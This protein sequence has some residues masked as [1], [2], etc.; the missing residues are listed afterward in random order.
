MAQAP[1]SHY[2]RTPNAPSFTS[3]DH[4]RISA[5][6]FGANFLWGAM[7]GP[8]LAHQMTVLAPAHS[9]AM[10]GKLMSV[11]AWPA[12]LI[13]LFTG[14]FSD[15]CRSKF[16]RRRPFIFWG[17]LISVL[18]LVAMGLAFS[19]R[20]LIPYI[21]AYFVIQVGSNVALAAYS[22]V[23]PD[24]VP[25]D[26]LGKASGLMAVMSQLGTL[27]GAIVCGMILG[28]SVTCLYVIAAVL[29]AFVGFT[30][31]SLR[32][33][34]DDQD[35]E[36]LRIGQVF[37]S[38]WID[39]RQYPDFAWVWL[40]RALMMLGFYMIQP[41]MQFYMHDLLHVD[42]PAKQSAIVFAVI[43]LAACLSGFFGGWMS[44][45]FGR[46]RIVVYSTLI[47]AVMSVVFIFLNNLNQALLAG[48]LFGI[49]YGAYISVDWALGTDVLPK[50]EDAASDMAVWHI[51]MTAPQI[52]GPVIAGTLVLDH[53]IVGHYVSPEGLSVAI[54][55]MSG[56]AVVF[57]M[58]AL[59][60]F[61]SGILVRKV[62]GST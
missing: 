16:G 23:I 3:L 15:R 21:A 36:A 58:C 45:H 51:A 55:G 33:K 28:G 49:G 31:L 6:W 1:A 43:L 13:P 18:G 42:N 41:Y 57:S 56:Y 5:Y 29:A 62:K 8:V 10:L 59:F 22:G 53:A 12:I 50:Q 61:L 40:T 2:P 26:Q 34:P 20:M 52:I 30:V 44:D 60:F 14:P 39:P 32:D 46:K 48:L 7:L 38:L 24:E 54:Y 35:R 25:K 47:I 11:A 17:G 37:K 19:S 9:A 4:L 27:A